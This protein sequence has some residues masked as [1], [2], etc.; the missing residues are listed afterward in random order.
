MQRPR[1]RGRGEGEHIGGQSKLLQLLLVLHAEAV[2]LVD[3]DEAE[4]AEAD[5]VAQQ[6]MRSDHDVDLLRGQIGEQS[7]L[8][9]WRLEARQGFD[10]N[11]KIRQSLAEGASVLFGENRRR[12]EDG[13]LLPGL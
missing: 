11:G 7:G 6:T 12:H 2:L 13:N 1:D 10:A 5:V 8:L 9:L 4:I 3:D